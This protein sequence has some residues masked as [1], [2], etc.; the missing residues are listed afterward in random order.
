VTISD[1][2]V[3]PGDDRRPSTVGAVNDRMDGGT[4]V[5]A[6]LLWG[7]RRYAA[8]VLALVLALGVLL[9]FALAQRSE[10][11]TATAQVGPSNK[12]QL[13]NTTPLPRLAESVFN[14]G[15]VE[16][17]IRAMLGQPKGNIIPSRVQLIAAQD[18]LVL[19]VVAKA[20]TAAQAI[21]I[22]NQAA[23]T[24][25]LELSKYSKSVAEFQ[26]T[27]NAVLAK[28][29]P[30]IG[31]GYLSVALGLLAGLLAG[32]GV[33]GLILVIRRPVVDPSTAR[34]VTGSP[35]LGRVSMPRHGPPTAADTR[36]IGLLCRR[37]STST[38]SSLHVV[39][40]RKGLADRLADL[41]KES[42]MRM[43][44]MRRPQKRSG[45]QGSP[46]SVPKVVAPDGAE[47]WLM[48]ADGATYTLLLAPEG[49]STRKLRA[50][51]ES[52]DTGGP[53]GVV[54]VT[55]HRGTGKLFGKF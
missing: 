23:T 34:V 52:H 28:K 26:I 43:R 16:Q 53:R 54:M 13:P 2:P 20:P 48:A 32:V 19:E 47:T 31:G 11:Y 1:L 8:L 4:D 12:F 25:L 7:L 40:P 3:G 44:E 39:A 33:V 51:T 14:N 41:M 29:V 21:Q 6:T 24:F 18:N 36:T 42:F 17:K 30:K 38:A 50:F 22:A 46:P 49:I 55:T 37:L 10:V 9:P 27:H 45:G 15:A 35:V 5:F